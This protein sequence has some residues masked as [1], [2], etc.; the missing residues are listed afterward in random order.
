[1]F[2]RPCPNCIKVTE[3]IFLKKR[4]LYICPE[5]EEEFESLPITIIEPQT[6]FLSYAHKSERKEDYDISEELVWLIKKELDK[7]GHTVWI[8]QEGIRS[9]TQ[10]REHITSAILCHNH[11][12]S[13]LSK[14]SVRE[15]GVCLNEIAIALGNGKQIQTLLTESE[16]SVFQP[17]TISHIQW[18]EF[19]DWKAIKDGLQTGPNGENWETWFGQ[20]MQHI[21]ENLSDIEKIKVAGDLQRLKD[22]LEPKSFEAEIIAKIEGFYGRRWLFEECN[23]WLN[24]S[25]NRLFWLK[26][27]PGIGKSAFAAKLVHQSNSAIIGFF[28]CEFQGNKSPEVSASECIRT[29]AYQLATRLPDYRLK[30]LYQ[31]LIDKE[32]I[33]KKSSDDLFTFLITEPLNVLGKI[34]EATRL[35]IVIDALDEAGRNDGTNALAD[36]M[37]KH[38]DNLPPWL[39]I[40][41]TSRPEPYLEQQFNR[42]E[43]TLIEGGTDK[44]LQDIKDYLQEQLD[45]LILEPKRSEIIQQIIEK[46]GGIFLYLKLIEKDPGLSFS[47]P[48]GLPNGIDDIFMRDFKRYFPNQEDYGRYVEPFLRLMA[49][50]P[51]PLPPDLAHQ[52]LGWTFREISTRVTQPLGSLIQDKKGY[53]FFHKSISDWLQDSKRSGPYLVETSGA[54]NLGNFLLAEYENI[55]NTRWI[56]LILNWLPAL[57]QFTSTWNNSS[58]LSEVGILFEKKLK[59]STALDFCRRELVLIE[60][61][62]GQ[63]DEFI[64]ALEKSARLLMDLANYKE[65]EVILKNVIS[66]KIE[67]NNLYSMGLLRSKA[68]LADLYHKIAFLDQAEIIYRE[69]IKEYEKDIQVSNDIS[70]EINLDL[71]NT[72]VGLGS[73]LTYKGELEEAEKYIR[74]SLKIYQE[75]LGDNAP[76]TASS[77]NHLAILLNDLLRFDEAEIYCLKALKFFKENVGEEHPSYLRQL[78]NYAAILSQMNQQEEAFHFFKQVLETRIKILGDSHPDTAQSFQNIANMYS[79]FG[80][81]EIAETFYQKALKIRVRLFDEENYRTNS[82]MYRLANLYENINQQDKANELYNLVKSRKSLIIGVNFPLYNFDLD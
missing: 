76:N 64:D 36:L 75:V 35:A 62:S 21:R 43:A 68:L 6:I 27:S 73:V 17:L 61:A 52:V 66:L 16:G 41:F 60:N 37:Y 72:L 34:P 63:G 18:H 28:K 3:F 23:H 53:V 25:K 45:P 46:S 5:C 19:Q 69:C 56:D 77:F 31:Q 15:P 7:D 70:S 2:L 57:I 81:Y 14:R 78:N 1:M 33:E 11:F 32:K 24:H 39:G 82:T 13:F 47:S 10:W 74:Y 71:A 22:I 8:D 59:Y 20:R 49:A 51:G 30:L 12:L 67:S 48:D 38:V 42:F 79:L 54:A 40:I 26:G 50:A 65:C 55:K 58:K 29:L 9:G 44:N 80:D 4:N